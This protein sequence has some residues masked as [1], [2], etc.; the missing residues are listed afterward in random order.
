MFLIFYCKEWKWHIENFHFLAPCVLRVIIWC[1]QE[2][3]ILEQTANDEV[4]ST[5]LW[6]TTEMFGETLCT[7]DS[8]SCNKPVLWQLVT[9]LQVCSIYS[10]SFLISCWS[11]LSPKYVIWST[12]SNISCRE[13]IKECSFMR[14]SWH[15]LLMIQ[16]I[17]NSPP[18]EN[19]A[20]VFPLISS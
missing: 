15:E 1:S 18:N 3:F 13:C 9:C 6:H 19:S 10:P 5:S 2:L 14:H 16:I 7:S 12:H 8:V 11:L 20:H 17:Q 4:S